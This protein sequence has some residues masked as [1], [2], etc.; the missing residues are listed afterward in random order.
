MQYKPKIPQKLNEILI[1]SEK[2][3]LL[4]LLLKDGRKV[5]CKLDCLTYTNASDDEDTDVMA[6]LVRYHNGLEEIF[7][8]D[9][10]K[11]VL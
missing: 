3:E 9:D 5:S 10:I 11:Q 4:T 7:I 2:N 8:D 6:A 1:K